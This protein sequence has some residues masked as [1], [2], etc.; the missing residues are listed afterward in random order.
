M[1]R[2]RGRGWVIEGPEWGAGR[3]G[4]GDRRG[5]GGVPARPEW[6]LIRIITVIAD[7]LLCRF[8]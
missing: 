3:A 6:G 4:L 1:G 8:T 7:K 2:L 5:R